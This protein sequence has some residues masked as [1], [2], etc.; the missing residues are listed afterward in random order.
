MQIMAYTVIKLKKYKLSKAKVWVG[1]EG[2]G[3]Y[4][5]FLPKP[6]YCQNH[7]KMIKLQLK[8]SFLKL[9]ANYRGKPSVMT[10]ILSI[11]VICPPPV[12]SYRYS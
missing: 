4:I 5:F 11:G 3:V 9:A 12:Q 2:G 7:K 6:G 10:K 8:E 1:K